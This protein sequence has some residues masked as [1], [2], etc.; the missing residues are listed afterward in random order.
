MSLRVNLS[1]LRNIIVNG[2][3]GTVTW[4][5]SINPNQAVEDILNHLVGGLNQNVRVVLPMRYAITPENASTT[6]LHAALNQTAA[7][8]LVV[9]TAQPDFPRVV[10]IAG[11]VSGQTGNV[12][13]YGTNYAGE[14]IT[15]TIALS[16]TGTVLG[17][18]AFKTVTRFSVPV[19]THTPTAQVETAVAVTTA[20]GD[21]T[22][23]VTVTAAG[24][25]GSP[26]ATEVEILTG[27]TAAVWA[28][29]VRAALGAVA[30]ITALFTVG[31][32]GA[33]I[34]LTKKAPAANDATLNIAI[35]D[36][37]TT[38]ITP[39]V[40]STNTTA[41][42]AYDTVSLGYANKFGLPNKALNASMMLIA[43]FDGSADTGGTLAVDSDL[44]K[45]LYTMAGTPDGAKVLDL[46]Y[47]S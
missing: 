40:T 43:L 36:T 28:G 30:A 24:L 14:A 29:K 11:G 8:Q 20:T 15:D 22:I 16:G 46:T 2:A 47:L 13:V 34:V 31:G 12:V 7:S 23:T 38:G 42:V 17:V 19:Q 4:N 39:V 41:G 27:D 25:A 3:V 44:S 32:T 9:P 1:K 10:E 45:N 26:L 33:N 35:A 5:N 6:A 37:D 21:G 18:K